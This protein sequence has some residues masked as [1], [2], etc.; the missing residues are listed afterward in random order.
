MISHQEEQALGLVL[1]QVQAG[2]HLAGALDAC[3]GMA[4]GIRGLADIVQEQREV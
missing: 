2:R 4:L 1:V 3:L